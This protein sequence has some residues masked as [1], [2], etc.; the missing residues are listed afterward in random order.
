MPGVQLISLSA[1]RKSPPWYIPS[2]F[3]ESRQEPF[4]EFLQELGKQLDFL[5]LPASSPGEIIHQICKR[6]KPNAFSFLN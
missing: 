3:P 5:H 1:F 4:F 6:G 2:K